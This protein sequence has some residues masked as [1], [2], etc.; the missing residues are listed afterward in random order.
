M[1]RVV[2]SGLGC[3]V[4]LCVSVSCLYGQDIALASPLP[5]NSS[6]ASMMAVYDLVANGQ[7]RFHVFSKQLLGD[8]SE[9]ELVLVDVDGHTV[10]GYAPPYLSN[11]SEARPLWKDFVT[12]NLSILASPEQMTITEKRQAE[13]EAFAV[14][15]ALDHSASMTTPRAI[16]MQRAVQNALKTFDPKDYVAVTKFTGSVETEVEITKDR[17]TYL[18]QFKV[19]GLQSRNNGTAIYDAA[20][21]TINQLASVA[22]VRNRVLVVFT[23]GEDQ[24][25]SATVEDV[26]KLATQYNV[27]VHCVLYGVSD[28]RE[29]S[30]LASET[31]GKLHK[32][33]DVYDF[34]RVF[35]GIY[36]ALRHTYTVTVKHNRDFTDGRVQGATM[37]AAGQGTGAVKTPEV[38]A[39]MPKG[40]VAIAN[41]PFDGLIMNVDLAFVDQSH[42]VNPD[43]VSLLDSI[44]TVMIQKGDLALEILNASN[45][46]NGTEENSAFMHRRAQAVRDLLIRRGVP[47]SRIQSYAG[48]SASASPVIRYAD[49]K[50]TT[51]VFTKM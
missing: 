50:K 13:N 31:N 45:G 38:M 1:N 20:I 43:D 9:I 42:D 14:G 25:S 34:D 5:M 6:A 47:P 33:Q 41:A 40:R 36:N 11:Q 39:M 24:S 16:R 12:A 10:G 17:N 46:G 15:F 35:L 28:D 27:A 3:V 2:K 21:E 30:K 23:D 48:K 8:K 44:A 22:D 49:P 4:A 51:F 18:G 26:V 37:T 29:I 7:A 19:N 32:L